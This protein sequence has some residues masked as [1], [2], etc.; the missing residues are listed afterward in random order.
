MYQTLLQMDEFR[1]KMGS[2]LPKLSKDA[3]TSRTEFE[4]LN[5]LME[6]LS[7]HKKPE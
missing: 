7:T 6:Y 3:Q 2:L 5:D 4:G 1:L